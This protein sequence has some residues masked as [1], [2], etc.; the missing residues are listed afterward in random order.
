MKLS[1]FIYNYTHSK[2]MLEIVRFLSKTT[3]FFKTQIFWE[4]LIESSNC[5][6][7]LKEEDIF[8]K[9]TKIEV[10]SCFGFII[11]GFRK[12]YQLLDYFKKY[13][14]FENHLTNLKYAKAKTIWK[15]FFLNMWNFKEV[16]V[17]FCNYRLFKVISIKG[18]IFFFKCTKIEKF[19]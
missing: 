10:N 17:L 3:L 6:N 11:R 8:F 9:G 12:W 16:N 5:K 13:E 14:Y 18:K 15:L 19:I 4:T 7:L 1:F 2:I